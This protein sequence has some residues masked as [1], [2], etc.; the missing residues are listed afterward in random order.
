[1]IYE[2]MNDRYLFV[3]IGEYLSLPQYTCHLMITLQVGSIVYI[4]LIING[5]SHSHHV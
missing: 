3:G 2:L 1:M 4:S 5:V